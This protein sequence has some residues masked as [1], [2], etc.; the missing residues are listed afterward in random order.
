MAWSRSGE[1]LG[2]LA[3]NSPAVMTPRSPVGASRWRSR[4][5]SG[6][7]T[8][9]LSC[10]TFRSRMDWMATIATDRFRGRRPLAPALPA[11]VWINKPAPPV[12]DIEDSATRVADLQR[13]ICVVNLGPTES[14]VC[15]FGFLGAVTRDSEV[16]LPGRLGDHFGRFPGCMNVSASG[17]SA[18]GRGKLSG[19][20]RRSST[21][22]WQKG[23]SDVI[24]HHH[25]DPGKTVRVIQPPDVSI[26]LT[27]SALPAVV[28]SGIRSGGWHANGPCLDRSAVRGGH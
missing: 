26:S 10:P 13:G 24:G 15:P 18:A 3:V 9:T 22:N 20:R 11:K 12:R 8:F 23:K 2:L 25:R 7:L 5:V 19:R 28:S 4:T 14:P 27:G 21:T 1:D 17:P 6:P 16:C